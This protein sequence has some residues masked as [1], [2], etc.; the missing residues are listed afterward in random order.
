MIILVLVENQFEEVDNS[1]LGLV[2]DGRVKS[3]V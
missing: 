2:D 3:G 1:C